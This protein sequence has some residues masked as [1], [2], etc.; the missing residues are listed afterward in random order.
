MVLSK[1]ITFLIDLDYLIRNV[2]VIF[3][4]SSIELIKVTNFLKL[5]SIKQQA[6][7]LIPGPT[8]RYITDVLLKAS[9][10]F[11]PVYHKQTILIVPVMCSFYQYPFSSFCKFVCKAAPD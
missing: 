9:S 3:K 5:V 10:I 4:N 6:P 7:E 8:S 1:S 11:C 2:N